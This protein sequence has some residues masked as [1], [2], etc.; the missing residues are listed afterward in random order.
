MQNDGYILVRIDPF[1]WNNTDLN[2][3]EKLI[4]NLIYGFTDQNKCCELS[5][6]W[7]AYKFGLDAQLVNDVLELMER[8][9]IIKIAPA[10]ASFPRR[11]SVNLPDMISPCLGIEDAEFTEE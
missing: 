1:I 6:E 5:N 7:I 4:L 3:Y 10:R 2:M 9:G 11:M 8:R